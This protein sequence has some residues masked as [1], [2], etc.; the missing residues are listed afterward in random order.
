MRRKSSNNIWI[1]YADLFLGIMLSL[2][3]GFIVVGRELKKISFSK[4]LLEAVR[5]AVEINTELKKE[6]EPRLKK[7][8]VTFDGSET[9]IEIP[10]AALFAQGSFNDF[11]RDA[12]SGAVL[13]TIASSMR[14]VFERIGEEK[15]KTIKIV[16]EG[17][18][19]NIPI[20]RPGMPSNWE[21][22]SRRATGV[23]RYLS[24]HG[25]DD[26]LYRLVAV[27]YADKRPKTSNST[28]EG[29]RKNR[30]IVIKIEP[31]LEEELKKIMP[32]VDATPDNQESNTQ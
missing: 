31:D 12:T 4:E 19:D 8:G 26:N 17:H 32:T 29:R 20:N 27:G 10:E 24:I 25:V 22:S 2:L 28:T 16:I 3:V 1:P 14:E 18:T 15:L 6:L 30:R 11:E 7:S 13:R 5:T 21:L 23:L 9:S